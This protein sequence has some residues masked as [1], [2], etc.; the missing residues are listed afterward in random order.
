MAGFGH[1]VPHALLTEIEGGLTLPLA[2]LSL[3]ALLKLVAFSDRNQP[4][5]LAGIFHCLQ[6]YLEHDERRYGVEHQGEGVP[7]EYT[8][9]YLLGVDGRQFLDKSLCDTVA[10][11]LDR[12]SDPDADVI[13]VIA[14]EKGL[15][16]IE[17]EERVQIFEHFRWYRLGAEL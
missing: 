15:R 7:Y 6:H 1:V 9:A 2:P 5:D 3:Y 13:A 14:R 12:F 16:V 10:D 17:E 8:C 4:K 11:V